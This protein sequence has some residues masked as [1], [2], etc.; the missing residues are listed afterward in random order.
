MAQGANRQIRRKVAMPTAE[1]QLKSIRKVLPRQF[2]Q[3]F[4]RL[5]KRQKA[6]LIAIVGNPPDISKVTKSHWKKWEDE[7]AA[8]L[9]SLM[10][11][12]TIAQTRTAIEEFRN[13]EL[14]QAGR[15]GQAGTKQERV[16]KAI[17][18]TMVTSTRRRAKF[19]AE[20]IIRTTEA[21]LKRGSSPEDILSPVRSRMITVTEMTAARSA[22]VTSMYHELQK[23]DVACELVWRLRPCQ[24][25]DV[26]PLLAD[27]VYSFWSRFVPSGP[28]VHLHCCCV[29]ELIFGEYKELLSRGRIKLGPSPRNVSAA[30]RKSGF[31]V[32]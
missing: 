23:A 4:D 12:Y 11:G 20:S 10:L 5:F 8:A 18:R 13:M 19:A 27:T 32:R 16:E 3:R 6:A 28:P 22:A 25:C 29:L 7:Q 2:E 26:C 15:A 24:H 17:M 1:Q 30:I 31:K 21:R 14:L 9:L